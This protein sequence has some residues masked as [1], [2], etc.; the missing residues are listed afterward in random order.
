MKSKLAFLV[1]TAALAVSA[2]APN[3]MART[4]IGNHAIPRSSAASKPKARAVN[5][6]DVSGRKVLA[7]ARPSHAAK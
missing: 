3:A 5:K 4:T 2:S 1:L 6:K 7:N